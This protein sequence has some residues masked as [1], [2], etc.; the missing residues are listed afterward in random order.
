VPHGL[1]LTDEALTQLLHWALL[2]TPTAEDEP[3][4]RGEP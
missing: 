1:R 4:Q 2:E 3:R